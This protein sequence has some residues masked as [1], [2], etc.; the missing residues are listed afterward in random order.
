[1]L[2]AAWLLGAQRAA[3]L[4]LV[5]LLV[6]GASRGT[7]P[8]PQLTFHRDVLPIL[9]DKCLRCHNPRK[10][11]GA[12]DMSTYA[13]L[14]RGGNSGPPLVVGNSRRSLM[15]D[16]I[17]F[18]EMPPKNQRPRVSSAELKLLEEWIDAGA[19]EG[20]PPGN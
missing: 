12:L 11:D 7:E 2:P 20:S 14:L 19:A 9:R 18:D 16:M 4:L 3:A 6:Q 8:P 13:G 15:I 10:K 1:L 17:F 5:V